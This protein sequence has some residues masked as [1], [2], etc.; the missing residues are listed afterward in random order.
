MNPLA[1]FLSDEYMAGAS[2]ALASHAGFS[3]A[4]SDVELSV[5]FVVTDSPDGDVDYSLV[6][7]DGEASLSR[8]PQD[9]ADVTVTNSYETAAGISKGELNTQMAFITG[10]LKV[11][12][13]M[14]ALMRH[15]GVVNQ[16]AEAVRD[17][18][19]EY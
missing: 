16:F 8:G 12:G 4:I 13:N 11:A 19:V 18:E 7:R 15:Q 17:L 6:I 1:Q 10:K 5:Q 3:N 14:A 2:D 9:D